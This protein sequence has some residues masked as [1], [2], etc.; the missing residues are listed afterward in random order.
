MELTPA[1]FFVPS[2]S[3]SY[4]CNLRFYLFMI[5][6]CYCSEVPYR[7]HVMPVFFRLLYSC[8]LRLSEARLLKVCDVDL[9]DGVITITNAKLDKHRQ[10]PISPQ[11]LEQL[12]NTYRNIHMF[13]TSDSWFFPGFKDKPMTIALV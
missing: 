4:F 11:L 3:G 6:K 13:S 1:S 9:N 7:H 2:N 5:F 8:G 12:N 10:I